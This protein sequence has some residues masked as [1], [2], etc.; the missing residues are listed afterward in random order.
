MT[1]FNATTWVVFVFLLFQEFAVVIFGKNKQTES[2][3]RIVQEFANGDSALNKFGKDNISA[4][5]TVSDWVERYTEYDTAVFNLEITG[6][7]NDF[8]IEFDIVANDNTKYL[9]GMAVELA[10]RDGTTV[11]PSTIKHFFDSIE[12]T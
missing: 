9:D 4:Y 5:S 10:H 3:D 12:M 7:E 2:K 6:I 1:K 8:A 11:H